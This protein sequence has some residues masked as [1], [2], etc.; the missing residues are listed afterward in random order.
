MLNN[1]TTID[2]V[3]TTTRNNREIIYDY[4][5]HVS[6]AKR[7]IT[8][9]S[10]ENEKVTLSRIIYGGWRIS[11]SIEISTTISTGNII[12]TPVINS[13]INGPVIDGS[14]CKLTLDASTT[15]VY[16]YTLDRTT[17]QSTL[18]LTDGSQTYV[19]DISGDTLYYYNNSY[20][21]SFDISLGNVNNNKVTLDIVDTTISQ[22]SFKWNAKIKLVLPTRIVTS[23]LAEIT[24]VNLGEVFMVQ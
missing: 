2:T 18:T 11:W 17:D 8:A 24:G 9:S 1:H 4:W 7:S 23:I 22:S 10:G 13:T 3:D 5:R 20:G 12:I 14:N 6:K 15:N 16:H 19:S 21:I